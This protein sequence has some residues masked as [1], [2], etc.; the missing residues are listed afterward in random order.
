[1]KTRI[2]PHKRE[3]NT[4]HS[5]T[6]AQLDGGAGAGCALAGGA[7]AARTTAKATIS[8]CGGPRAGICA[9]APPIANVARP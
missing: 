1:M 2:V 8:R 3:S 9:D 5:A 6:M 7:K 4:P